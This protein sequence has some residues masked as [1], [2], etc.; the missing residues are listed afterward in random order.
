MNEETHL[1]P[2]SSLG[3]EPFPSFLLR[4]RLI[5]F[6]HAAEEL[7]LVHVVDCFGGVEGVG[8]FD[9]GEAA[10]GGGGGFSEKVLVCCL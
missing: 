10:V 7:G 9:V 4:F 1:L 6:E 2:N 3:P 5:D 8:E